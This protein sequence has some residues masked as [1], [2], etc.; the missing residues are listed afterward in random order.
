MPFEETVT[1]KINTND[2]MWKKRQEEKTKFALIEFQ[3]TWPSTV[4]IMN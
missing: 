1:H 4:H 2:L 3:T